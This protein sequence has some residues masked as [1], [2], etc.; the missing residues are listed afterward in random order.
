MLFS[1]AKKGV[2][3]LDIGSSAIMLVELREKKGEFHLQRLGVEPL[4]PEAIVDGKVTP[5]LC[6]IADAGDTRWHQAAD[7]ADA[8][9]HLA[10]QN[11]APHSSWS[12]AAAA[13]DMMLTGKS[14]DAREQHYS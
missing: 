13:F 3:G 6:D 4:S 8:I 10:A 12:E 5:V 2:V 7:R 11:P 9:V 1:R 14:V